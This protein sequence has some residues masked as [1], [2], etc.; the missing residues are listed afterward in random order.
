MNTI[1]IEVR[2]LGDIIVI[3]LATFSSHKQ[4]FQRAKVKKQKFDNC[5]NIKDHFEA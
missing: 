2:K 1:V 4:R 3:I 5:G